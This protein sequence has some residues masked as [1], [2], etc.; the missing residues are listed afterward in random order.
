MTHASPILSCSSPHSPHPDC[1]GHTPSSGTTLP[2]CYLSKAHSPATTKTLALK[3]NTFGCIL[4]GEAPEVE[5]RPHPLISA[6][7]LLIHHHQITSQGMSAQACCS[8][9]LSTQTSSHARGPTPPHKP[10][11]FNMLFRPPQYWHHLNASGSGPRK[12]ASCHCNLWVCNLVLNT[13][14]SRVWPSQRR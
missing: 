3:L 11:K 1:P 13:H 12:L 5:P 7:P 10:H 14:F 4:P 8:Q 6:G 2:T 9:S